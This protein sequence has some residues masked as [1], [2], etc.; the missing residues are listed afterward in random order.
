MKLTFLSGR[1]FRALFSLLPL[2]G[3][4]VLLTIF[5]AEPGIVTAS[6]TLFQSPQDTP[7]P[8]S[9]NTPL[10]TP[11]N[12]AMPAATDTPPPSATAA[13]PTDTP[14]APATAL[15]T[16]SP[17]TGTPAASPTSEALQMPLLPPT[18]TPESPLPTPEPS[19]T[20]EPGLDPGFVGWSVVIVILALA[21]AVGLFSGYLLKGFARQ[22]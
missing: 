2:A 19:I 20:P 8:A 3:V 16:S 12:T 5:M 1:Q 10:P 6:R 15:P 11:T 22:S 13:P 14:A 18:S 7:T 9:T 17:P 21:A 4:V